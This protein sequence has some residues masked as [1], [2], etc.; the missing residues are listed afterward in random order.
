MQNI[1]DKVTGFIKLQ[2]CKATIITEA[3]LEKSFILEMSFFFF[4]KK[5]AFLKNAYIL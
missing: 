2:G 1:S 5:S 4:F 3:G